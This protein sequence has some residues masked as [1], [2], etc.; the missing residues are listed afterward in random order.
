MAR[1]VH[2]TVSQQLYMERPKDVSNVRIT[3]DHSASDVCSQTGEV[4]SPQFMRDRAALRR[5]SVMSDGDQ[6]QQQQQ[7]RMGIGFN[8]SNKLIYEDLSGILGLKRMNSESSSELSTPATA[9]A[10]ERDNNAYP[11]NTNRYQWEYNATGQPSGAYAD[12]INRGVQLG[13]T[14]PTLYALESPRSCYP[15][16]AGLGDFSVTGKMKFLCSFGGRILPRPN[17]G[18][19]RYVGG[20]TRIISIRKNV[21]CEEL[22]KKTY[23]VCKYAHT[24]KYQLPGEDLDSLISVCSDEDLHHM[25]DEYQELENA[26]GSQRLRIFLISSNDCSDASPTSIEGRAVQPI[27]VDYQYVAAVNGMLDPSLQ[28][29]SSGQSFTSQTSQV[30]TIS[31]QSSNFRTDSSHATDVKDANSHKPNLAGILPR[32]GGKLLTPIQVPH[33]SY[34]QSSLISPV[35]VM[36]KDLKHLDPTYAE[37][38]RNFTPF[39]SEKHPCDTVYFVDALGRH[40]HLYHGSPLINY[41]HEKTTSETDETYK[42]HSGQF[43]RS[44]SEDF[45]P[46]PSWG[47]SDTHSLKIMLKERAIN[48]EHPYSDPEYSM[49][50]RSGT[51]HKGQRMMLV[52]SHSE[53][54]LLEQDEKS[55]HGGAYPLTSFNG[56]DQSPSLAM[57][58]SLQDFPTMWKQKVDSEYQD[59]SYENHGNFA[60]GC[61]NERCE[62]C[63]FDGK[64]ANSDGSIYVPSLDGD[65]KYKYL[66]HLDYQQSES[67]SGTSTERGLELEN[68]ENT[69]GGPS[70]IYHLEPTARKKI[71]V[72][73]YSDKNQQT[74]SDIVRSQPLSCASSDLRPLTTRALSDKTIIN[75]KPVSISPFLE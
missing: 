16:G 17:D 6:Q 14:T 32:P 31:D 22:T 12:E 68:S 56:S 35:T 9:Y 72:G 75:Q 4:F 2:E 10:A 55:N 27:D 33:E 38:A 70:L 28:R 19:L 11:N 71:G 50:L 41:H 58:N 46:A 66:R 40:N 45:V 39:V 7:K 44:S 60:S 63:N 30:G 5:L 23:A 51:T 61:E 15:G 24:I 74:S 47:Q 26:G 20:E 59:A 8:P 29:S 25:I 52:H 3:A 43:P 65:K 13:P 36:Q 21:L 73:Q 18:K 49:H 69:M 64:K 67:Q 1:E 57:S 48:Y 42:V 37:D 54:L 34:N 62:E 53:P